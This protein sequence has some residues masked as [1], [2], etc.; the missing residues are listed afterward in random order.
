MKKAVVDASFQIRVNSE[1]KEQFKTL[2]IYAGSLPS[3]VLRR[4]IYQCVATNTING[5][6]VIKL[7]KN[8]I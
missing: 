5:V 2:C 3:D 6:K 4:Y 7:P 8:N 1:V